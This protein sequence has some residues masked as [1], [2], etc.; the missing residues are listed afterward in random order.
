METPYSNGGKAMLCWKCNGTGR[1]KQRKKITVSDTKTAAASPKLVSVL[2]D[3]ACP[4]CAAAGETPAAPLND[5][6]KALPQRLLKKGFVRPFNPKFPP[7]NPPG[8]KAAVSITDAADQLQE[9]EMITALCGSWSIFQLIQ[10]HRYTTDDLATAAIAIKLY[11]T[12][13]KPTRHIDIGCGL[14]SVLLFVKWFL[15]ET[16]EKSVG[17]E[18]QERHCDLARKSIAVNMDHSDENRDKNGDNNDA[19]KNLIKKK[20]VVISEVRQGDLR[21]FADPTTICQNL[22]VDEIE[23]FDLVTGTPP[24]FPLPNGVVPTVQGRGMCSFELRGGVETY[25]IA[26][27]KCLA[28]TVNARFVF[29]QTAIEIERSQNAVWKNGMKV[30]ER[31]DFLGSEIKKAPL[32]VVF[33]CG[34][35]NGHKEE[36]PVRTIAVRMKN[37]E[38]SSEYHEFLV[39]VGK[40]PVQ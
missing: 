36:Y 19:N 38:Y 35:G 3:V 14:G 10:G 25:C 30:L 8:P 16:L 34:W 22:S 39:L 18:A 17:I 9:G 27:S 28:R 20:N 21:Q 5:T 1:K 32:F 37:G 29:V 6:T 26:A 4:L 13:P 7:W 40:P 24:Y 11:E 12:I 23:S 33:V 15:H 2:I 31:V